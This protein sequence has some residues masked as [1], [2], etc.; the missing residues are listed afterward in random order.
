MGARGGVQG[1][2][3]GA[4]IQLWSNELSACDPREKIENQIHS[5]GQPRAATRQNTAQFNPVPLRDLCRTVWKSQ[6]SASCKG[7]TAWFLQ[8]WLLRC[9]HYM[10]ALPKLCTQTS[11]SS[12]MNVIA[13]GVSV[14]FDRSGCQCKILHLHD[15]QN[16]S[17]MKI[18]IWH[19][20][21]S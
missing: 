10:R 21:F 4:Q 2:A 17:S 20:A 13:H 1:V 12:R 8:Q 19:Q 6:S 5:H 9:P 18:S 14:Y 3:V 7:G 16:Y 11:N 15:T